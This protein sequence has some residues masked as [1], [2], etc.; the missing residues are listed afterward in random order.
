[1]VGLASTPCWILASPAKDGADINQ[2][3]SGRFQQ[4]SQYEFDT[5]E[6]LEVR[7]TGH[8]ING[9]YLVMETVINGK[10]PEPLQR[11]Q[12]IIAME[13]YIEYLVQSGPGRLQGY[14]S[15]ML[16]VG[17]SDSVPLRYGP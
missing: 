5:G 13:P 12:E 10:L 9:G 4:Q 3:T 17:P 11:R 2:L 14:G 16:R 1:M 6:T 8:G 7:N 15:G